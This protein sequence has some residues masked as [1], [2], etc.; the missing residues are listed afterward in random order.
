MIRGN[1]RGGPGSSADSRGSPGCSLEVGVSLTTGAPGTHPVLTEGAS[2]AALTGSPF[3]G[4]GPRLT[5][6]FSRFST[7]RRG[8]STLWSQPWHRRPMSAP[9]RTTVQSCWP[10]GWGF[11]RRTTSPRYSTSGPSGLMGGTRHQHD[12]IEVVY[13][14]YSPSGSDIRAFRGQGFSCRPSERPSFPRRGS[15]PSPSRL[16]LPR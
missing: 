10:Q 5:K 4:T 15:S 14:G 13:S 2:A 12:V 6:V 11:R 1:R 9:R 16:A 3:S 8:N 7:T